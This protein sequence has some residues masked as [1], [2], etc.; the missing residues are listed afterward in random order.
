[1]KAKI[2]SVESMRRLKTRA[3]LD[4]IKRLERRETTPARLQRENSCFPNAREFR[5]ADSS[6]LYIFV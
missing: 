6:R 4:D 3:R 1:M 2:I 5:V